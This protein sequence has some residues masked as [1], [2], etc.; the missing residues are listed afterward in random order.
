M[1]EYSELEE[2]KEKLSISGSRC[3]IPMQ[4]EEYKE[5]GRQYLQLAKNIEKI[6]K[7]QSTVVS[8]LISKGKSLD[9]SPDDLKYLEGF[10]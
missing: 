3:S 8:Y 5:L 6:K 10:R 1:F 2:L 7:K 9:I 4:S